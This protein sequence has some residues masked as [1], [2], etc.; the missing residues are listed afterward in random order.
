MLR[1]AA[2][3]TERGEAA[4][5]CGPAGRVA[6]GVARVTRLRVAAATLGA[7]LEAASGAALRSADAHARFCLAQVNEGRVVAVGPGR[8]DK[9]GT[10]LPVG[11]R[12]RPRESRRALSVHNAS[13]ARP[14]ARVIACRTHARPHDARAA[15]RIGARG[16][17]GWRER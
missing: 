3:H 4:A 14:D 5:A 1:P 16:P 8:R 12:S 7:D 17:V 15:L 6:A 13:H 2:R 9:D 11:A 10:L